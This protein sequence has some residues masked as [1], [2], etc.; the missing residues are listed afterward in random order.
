MRAALGHDRLDAVLLTE[1]LDVADELDRE[2]MLPSESFCVLADR[3]AQRPGE[4]GEVEDPDVALGELPRHRLSVA[5]VGQ[6][7]LQEE[8]V[9]AGDHAADDVGVAVSQHRSQGNRWSIPSSPPPRPPTSRACLVPATLGLFDLL[10]KDVRDRIVAAAGERMTTS[11]DYS[12][13]DRVLR[14]LGANFVN[15]RYPYEK[16]QGMS[17]DEYRSHGAKWIEAGAPIE[18][19]DFIYHPEELYGLVWALQGHVRAWLDV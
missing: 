17:P 18:E 6:G 15:L 8:A 2:A 14:T 12:D 7:A 5:D 11:A 19:A 13:L 4:L 16:Y 1:R 3:F 10:P 9:E